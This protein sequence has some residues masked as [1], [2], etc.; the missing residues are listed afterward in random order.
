MTSADGHLTNWATQGPPVKCWISKIHL[1]SYA[2]LAIIS[3]W[4]LETLPPFCVT[5][6]YSTLILSS[7]VG[8]HSFTGSLESCSNFDLLSQTLNLDPFPELEFSL[9]FWIPCTPEIWVLVYSVP[10]H[11][12]YPVGFHTNN[13]NQNTRAEGES[14]LSMPPNHL[15]KNQYFINPTSLLCLQTRK[16]LCCFWSQIY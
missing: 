10:N 4:L 7:S 6:L 8:S 2:I 13:Y 1:V 14:R 9:N 11:I 16:V 5:H 15:F 3:T 12:L